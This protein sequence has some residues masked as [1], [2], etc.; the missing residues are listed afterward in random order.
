MKDNKYTLVNNSLGFNSY[1]RLM[2]LSKPVN[3]YRVRGRD[4]YY[5]LR[6]CNET[7]RKTF[8]SNMGGFIGYLIQLK[9]DAINLIG[10]PKALYGCEFIYPEYY[11]SY[12]C[13]LEDMGVYIEEVEPTFFDKLFKRELKYIYKV[14][15]LAFMFKENLQYYPEIKTIKRDLH[16]NSY[17]KGV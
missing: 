7:D 12:N 1:V 10:D 8:Y 15:S 11:Q 6:F 17:R 4:S 13:S 16:Y 2:E 5:T 14:K 3:M 9:Q